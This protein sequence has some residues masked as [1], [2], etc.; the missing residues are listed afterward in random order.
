[1]KYILDTNIFIEA[2]N[3]YY[4]IDFCPAFWDWISNNDDVCSIDKVKDELLVRQDAISNWAQNH[5]YFFKTTD[6]KVSSSLQN[7]SIWVIP[8]NTINKIK[9]S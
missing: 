2:N 1:M 3:R 5:A 6:N 7:I 4:V 8:A 9:I